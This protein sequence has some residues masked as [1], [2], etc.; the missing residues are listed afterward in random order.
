MQCVSRTG[1]RETIF[2]ITGSTTSPVQSRVIIKV[3]RVKLRLYLFL[4]FWW[5]RNITLPT[6]RVR[7][8][9]SSKELRAHIIGGSGGIRQRRYSG[10][11]TRTQSVRRRHSAPATYQW[12]T[13]QHRETSRELEEKSRLPGRHS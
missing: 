1:S 4:R 7:V 12:K 2:Y 5:Q 13:F 8:T 10:R 3:L 11:P 9:D 6:K